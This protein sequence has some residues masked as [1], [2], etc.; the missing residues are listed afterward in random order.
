M[1]WP[2]LIFG[3]FGRRGYE[4]MVASVV[5]VIAIATVAGALMVVEGAADA[6]ARAERNDRPNVVQVMSRFNRALFETPRSGNLQPLTL[7]VYEPLIDPENLAAA[8][9]GA[10][11]LPRQS[12]LRNVVFPAS[13][14]NVYI[15]GIEPNLE[16]QFSSFVLARGRFLRSDDN[17]MAMVDKASARAL[18]VDLGDAFAVRKADGEDLSL[19][20]VGILDRLALHGAPPRTVE[21]PSLAPAS[22][23]VSSGVFVTLRTSEQIFGRETL[24]DALVVARTTADTPPLVD[25]LRTAF[26]LEPGVFVVERYSQFRRKVHDFVLTLSFFAAISAVTAI[27]S[28]AFV[29]NLL[30]DVYSDRRRQY[31][32]LIA[33]GFSPARAAIPGLGFGLAAAVVG[34]IAGSLLCVLFSG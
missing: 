26:R 24:T 20:V 8:A 21:T 30:H 12:F 29:A 16:R 22:S 2:K 6:L 31:A 9:G 27:L 34:T 13:F 17:A 25:R 18:G 28:G 10:T 23:V 1:I 11:V 15:F 4:A 3:G 14:L 7:P 19:T 33:L 5:L 32:T